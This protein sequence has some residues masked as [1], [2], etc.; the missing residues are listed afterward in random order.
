MKQVRLLAIML[1]LMGV[2]CGE[3]DGAVGPAGPQGPA[4]PTGPQGMQ[5]IQGEPGDPG[6]QGIQGI[7]GEPGVSPVTSFEG[8]CDTV[9]GTFTCTVTCPGVGAIALA[10]GDWDSAAADVPFA[11][12]L[13]SNNRKAD[14]VA[15]WE[16]NFGTE[17][18]EVGVP[19]N[20]TVVCF[21][22]PT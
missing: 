5:G 22:P 18:V 19:I 14:D 3:E 10:S 20:M 16:F 7:Q 9:A 15:S 1:A 13:N 2:G 17:G 8:T 4:G 12:Y 6:I 21:T 11:L